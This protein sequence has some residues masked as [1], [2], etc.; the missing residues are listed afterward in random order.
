[1]HTFTSSAQE[2]EARRSSS[3]RPAWSTQQLLC[4]PG[5]YSE[6]LT[7]KNKKSN[8]SCAIHEDYFDL[9]LSQF[10][11]SSSI[12]DLFVCLFVFEIKS[13]VL[14]LNSWHLPISASQVVG[15]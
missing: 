9:K 8:I 11:T 2:A 15:I 6:T 13:H 4:S 5:V 10:V 1:M 3:L 7:Q 14:A 12:S